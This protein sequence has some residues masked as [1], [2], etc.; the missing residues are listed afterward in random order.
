MTNAFI[1]A[2][3]EEGYIIRNVRERDCC[4][5][6]SSPLLRVLVKELAKPVSVRLAELVIA[7]TLTGGLYAFRATLTARG[8][9]S[10]PTFCAYGQKVGRTAAAE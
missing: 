4:G 7:G 9:G 2:L 3:Y 10:L 6:K 8:T 1:G 5:F